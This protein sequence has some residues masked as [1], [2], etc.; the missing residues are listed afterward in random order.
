MKR[1]I[2]VFMAII[3]AFT[4]CNRMIDRLSPASHIRSIKPLKGKLRGDD[5]CAG[6]DEQ[7][8][9]SEPD[10]GYVHVK[11]GGGYVA[12]ICVN[13]A[14]NSTGQH[15]CCTSGTFDLGQ[16]AQVKLP[17]DGIKLTMTAEEDIFVNSWSIVATENYPNNTVHACYEMYGTTT[18]PKW[19]QLNCTNQVR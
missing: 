15:F 1:V 12:K 13:G 16:T 2:I 11:N 18:D 8:C 10:C 3:I 19:R 4:D 14:F 17:C 7:L 9:N 6:C 5:V